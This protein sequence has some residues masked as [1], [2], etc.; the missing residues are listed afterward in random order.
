MRILLVIALLII[1]G[2][3]YPGNFSQPEPGVLENFFSDWRWMT[4]LSDM[5][6]NVVLFIPFGLASGLVTGSGR[7][8]I[9]R[10][11]GL[12]VFGLLLAF[13]LQLAQV[14]LPSRSAALADVVWNV[15]GMLLGIV[16]ALLMKKCLRAGVLPSFDSKL[17]VP[18]AILVL[19]LL[20]ELLPLVPTLDLQK[21]KDAI[22]PL[23][24]QFDFSLS[25]LILH[26]AGVVAAGAVVYV[27]SKKPLIW[28][29]SLILVVLAGKVA[30]VN[31]VLDTTVI[32]GLLAGYL[33]CVFLLR[34]NA[35]KLFDVSFWSLLLAW[36]IERITPFIVASDGAIN[37]IPFATMLE[38]SM[39]TNV[40][41][42]AQ[43]LFIY[44]ALLWLAQGMGGN[45]R[46][47]ATGVIVWS[48]L[49]ELTQ[50]ILLGRTADI[51]EPLLVLLVAWAL[52]ET[53]SYLQH[54]QSQSA[55]EKHKPSI[56]A[57]PL[58]TRD[59]STLRA[60][61]VIPLLLMIGMTGLLWLMLRLPGIPY[62]LRELFLGDGHFL[63]IFIFVLALLWVGAGAVWVS[64]KIVSSRVPYL[65]FPA[66]I[67]AA[68]LISLVLLSMSVTQESIADIA[69]SNNL[70]WYVI[71]RDIWGES[72]RHI[73]EW[74]GPNMV[75]I[76]ERPVRYAALYTP[77][78]VF[79]TWIVSFFNFY[80]HNR[81]AI[82]HIFPI[83]IGA[84]P[85]LWLAKAIVFDWSS[86]DN[87]NELIARDGP[88]GWGGGGYLY[89][90]L[91]I[92]C[93]NAV[94]LANALSHIKQ[95][96]FV[97]LFSI[98]ML[99]MGWWLLSQGLESEVEKYGHVFSGTQFLL[100][101]DRQHLLSEIELFLRWCLVQTSFV[102]M[103]SIGIR[104]FQQ[105]RFRESG[106]STMKRLN[107]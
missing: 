3:L 30:I 6:G 57:A 59:I 66:W 19:W 23:L 84:L 85:W 50:M 71:N 98:A 11:L 16:I 56:E 26:A 18:S 46:G 14:W 29:T 76:L 105:L 88:M 78:I 54:T 41:G 86:T 70:Y 27:L 51:T 95:L 62:N 79:L 48:I 61:W 80:E 93:F 37:L 83:I 40:T 96:A 67:F 36:T 35:E 42:L 32:L 52:S 33:T 74:I 25:G 1:Y 101:P 60:S 81:L 103:T 100:G 20:T 9:V 104:C 7:D 53:Q 55:S 44:T 72:W 92:V 45:L 82:R 8:T 47:I 91:A 106:S 68:S 13:I 28:L 102:I 21:F 43:S 69:G 77:L 12:F 10:M 34:Q 94:I 38:G 99:P 31:L 107:K 89:G 63:I 65:V 39:Q 5:L 87:L 15:V 49:L 17:I 2:S 4:S 73:F 64:N 58:A 24:L 22:K 97:V 90:L 75:M